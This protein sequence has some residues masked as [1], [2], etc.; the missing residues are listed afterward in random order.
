MKKFYL[1][2]Q[3]KVKSAVEFS[4][5]NHSFRNAGGVCRGLGSF[6]GPKSV[7]G[8][9]PLWSPVVSGC[10]SWPPVDDETDNIYISEVSNTVSAIKSLSQI[11]NVKS[12]RI[13]ISTHQKLSFE[14]NFSPQ[15]EQL[16]NKNIYFEPY[17]FLISTKYVKPRFWKLYICIYFNLISK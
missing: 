12:R 6:T 10:L 2:I 7:R 8:N 1:H 14:L 13:A 5:N 4:S 3:C 11:S 16:Q 15:K 9:W 17:G